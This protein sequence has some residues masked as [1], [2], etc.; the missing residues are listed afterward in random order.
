MGSGCCSGDNIAPRGDSSPAVVAASTGCF[1]TTDTGPGADPAKSCSSSL[2]SE[3]DDKDNDCKEGGSCCGNKPTK[4]NLNACQ[5]DCC[6][7]SKETSL[8]K[9]VSD[10]CKDGCCSVE[11]REAGPVKTALDACKDGCCGDQPKEVGFVQ[12]TPDAC[13]DA[14][15]SDPRE[16]SL[17][18]TAPSDCKDGCCSV[19]SKE[20]VPVNIVPNACRDG[21]CSDS[22]ETSLDKTISDICKDNCCSVE[23]KEVAP[24]KT[25]PDACKDA[26]CGDQPKN[27][28]LSEETAKS[29]EDA[30]CAD[31]NGACSTEKPAA[32]C[33]DGC[34]DKKAQAN[35]C[36]SQTKA[37]AG[38]CGGEKDACGNENRSPSISSDATT[39]CEDEEK[40]DEKCIWAVAAMECE[41]ACDEDIDHNE[42]EGH[43]HAHDKDGQHLNSAC[44]SHL[45]SAMSR[46]EAYIEQARCI[47]RSIL[48]SGLTQTSCCAARRAA[49][50]QA[51]NKVTCSSGVSTSK[52]SR[53]L[54]QE[55]QA[56]SQCGSK[57]DDLP[58]TTAKVNES[59]CCTTQKQR[60]NAPNVAAR[61][62]PPDLRGS[63]EKQKDLE[64]C[65]GIEMVAVS[66]NGM[67]CSGCGD[68]LTRILKATPGVSEVR[69]NFVM[70]NADFS[71]DLSVNKAKDVIKAAEGSTGFQITRL[72]GGDF[73]LDV[74]ASGLAARAFVDEPTD[75]I[76]DAMILD[77][78]TVRLSYDPSFI[79]ARDLFDKIHDRTEG[80]APPQ[81]DPS[82]AS[83]RKRLFDQLLKTCLA[84][85]LTIPVVVLAWG[86]N[87]VDDKTRAY[88]SIVLATLVQFI[89]VPE[90]YQ[91]ALSALVFSHVLEMD[92]LVVISITA[93]YLYSIVAF[94][95][96]M[97]NK[98]LETKEFF[99]TSTL[100][101]TLILLGR[102]IAT[103][104]RVKAVGA[105]SM[106]SLQSSNAVLVEEGK[107]LEIDARLL[108]YGDTFK[109]PPHSRVVTDGFVLSGHSEVDESM[110]TGES[111]P[112]PKQSGDYVIAGT[113]NGDGVITAQLTR[114]PGKN[115]VTD[116]AQMVEEATN[117]KPKI[118]DLANKVASWF[119]PVV[120]AVA[121]LVVIIW[122]VI[123]LRVR[124]EKTGRAVAD[125]ITYAV[126]VLAVSCPC[127]LGLAVPMVLVIA[128][129]IA[130]RGGI[131]IK[132]ADCTE[133]ARKCTDVIFDKTGTITEGDLYVVAEEVSSGADEE[134]ALA[135]AKAL[136]AGGKHPV[137]AA[138]ERHLEG[139]A[140][141]S[142]AAVIDV[143]VVP[144]AGVETRFND[145][146]GI[147]ADK[148]A[149]EKDSVGEARLRGG[150][151]GRQAQVR[152][153]LRR[154]DQPTRSQWR[155]R[156][157]ARR[158]GVPLSSSDVTQ[159][160][161]D[162]ILLAGLD[163]I[164]FLLDVSQA[165]FNRMV[166]NF[167][168]SAVYN[169]L[170]IL[171][172]A[173]A[174]VRVRI[175]PAYAGLGEI[176]SVLPVILAA[177]SMLLL[178]IRGKH[179]Q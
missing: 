28:N 157:S 98:P 162:V 50:P 134:E 137:S 86:D 8:D 140:V 172:A 128:G 96:R 152:H 121:V 5:D 32:S 94:G 115:T 49:A 62:S 122:V 83:G 146:V 65:S 55:P 41:K 132:S 167:A 88:V 42:A 107:D 46:Y 78:K 60:A 92:M 64:E 125:A 143:R 147:P 165:S 126:A 151:H 23:P 35:T 52:T 26:C 171:L 89:A 47:C 142:L 166:F 110:L 91:P 158:W 178:N 12:P 136:V 34:C 43:H 16:A 31:E 24:V 139:R 11:S 70:S 58:I 99:E 174:F 102:L 76:M 7:D 10:G 14:C 114:L 135:L 19:E 117:S 51:K 69:V 6:S 175:E 3:V 131:I 25:A 153:I 120:S 4:P 48:N 163:G 33:S 29:C 150:R 118:Q 124:N 82:L 79:G 97:A 133:S 61:A 81:A 30:C 90:F 129:G 84:A 74:L 119:V 15:C 1:G 156:T 104:A 95:F 75:G 45:Q 73:H 87:L 2:T 127:A 17:D 109:I 22:K 164:P 169:V 36:E 40:C 149:A 44:T 106:R 112:V 71:V 100:L 111:I 105:V 108:Q 9:P 144:G 63:R 101:I 80:L 38:C 27:K 66:V 116:I 54:R 145:A 170:A 68:K 155:R 59:S 161:A 37:S 20:V 113:V 13:K 160:A 177:L 168:W 123:G 72:A 103:Y 176:V 148:V 141:Q 39:C 154:R 67:T 138:T 159:G 85:V 173:G 18:K 56:K 179:Q 130:A 93:A 77:K 57:T 21:C 53:T